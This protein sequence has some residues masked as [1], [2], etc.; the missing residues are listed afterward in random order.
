MTHKWDM[1]L[2]SFSSVKGAHINEVSQQLNLPLEKI[3]S[4]F[5]P[6]NLLIYTMLLYVAQ[7]Y[8]NM[9]REAIEYLESEG[10][11]YSTIDESHFKSTN[12]AWCSNPVDQQLFRD[13]Q[14]RVTYEYGQFP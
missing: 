3:R 6:P 7:I 14:V 5:L 2:P 13:V 10:L 8:P 1:V 12:N 4:D 9:N 11:V